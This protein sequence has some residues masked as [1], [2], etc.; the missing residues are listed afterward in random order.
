MAHV[1]RTSS[2]QAAGA[3]LVTPEP[4]AREQDHHTLRCVHC[5]MHWSPS[6]GSGRDRGFCL[7]CAGVTCG[8]QRCETRCEPVERMIERLEEAWRV[9][10]NFRA[11]RG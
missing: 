11:M 1:L 7:R 8:K 6:Y 9:E 3:A 10:Q 2:R 4:G 5:G